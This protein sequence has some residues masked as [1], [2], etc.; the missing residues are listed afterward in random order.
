MVSVY[1][2]LSEFPSASAVV[3]AHITRLSNLL[4]DTSKSRYGKDA[5]VMFRE[6]TRS[7]IGSHMPAK[8][9]ELKHTIKLIRELDAKIE[10]ME[11]EIKAIMDKINSPILNVLGAATVWMQ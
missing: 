1:A 2:L 4:S 7:S 3:S 8:S 5:A 9:L 6:A 11:N 10:E